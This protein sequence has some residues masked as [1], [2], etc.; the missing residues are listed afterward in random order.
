[1]AF[2]T[3]EKDLP[4][5]SVEVLEQAYQT[6]G[7]DI[8][9]ACSFGVEGIILIDLIAKVNQRAEVVF[10][11]TDFHFQ[12]TYELIEKVQQLYP[13]LRIRMLKPELTPEEQAEKYGEALWQTDPDQCCG[14]RKIDP[15]KKALSGKKAWISGLRREQ[16]LSRK[17]VDFFNDD[18]K[19]GL[20]KVCPLIYWT[21]DDVWNYINDNHLPYNPLHDRGYPS[22]GCEYCTLPAADPNDLRSGRWADIGKTEC[23]LHSGN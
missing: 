19:F 1:M 21:W 7:E 8:V 9:Y 16:S 17:N 15:L 6:Y 2:E 12:E 3:K 10:L 22:I 20:T 18:R 13:A 23:G 11:D 5:E 14:I 4:K